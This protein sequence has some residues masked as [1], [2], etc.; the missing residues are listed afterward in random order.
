M[1]ATVVRRVSEVEAVGERLKRDY[2]QQV[3]AEYSEEIFEHMKR[4][5]QNLESFLA[6]HTIS[7]SLR[8]KMVDWMI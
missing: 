6:H 4:R 8:A 1:R 7:A 2:S 3:A 5:E